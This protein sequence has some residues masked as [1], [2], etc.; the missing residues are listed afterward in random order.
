MNQRVIYLKCAVPWQIFS[1]ISH[2]KLKFSCIKDIYVPRILNILI[3]FTCQ[4]FSCSKYSHPFFTRQIF[5]RAKC[6]YIYPVRVRQ[7]HCIIATF[8]LHVR[9]IYHLTLS[10]RNR[11]DATIPR[12]S[13]ARLR[14][15]AR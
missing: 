2:A 9:D 11:V 14:E 7:V 8:S 6:S 5:T 1:C 4:I 15:V 10:T 12:Q 3:H 13:R